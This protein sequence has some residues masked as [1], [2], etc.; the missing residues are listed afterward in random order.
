MSPLSPFEIREWRPSPT[1]A[2]Q[3]HAISDLEAGNVLYFPHLGFPFENGEEAMVNS[4]LALRPS[5]IRYRHGSDKLQGLNAQLLVRDHVAQILLR[6]SDHSFALVCALF[7]SYHLQIHPDTTRLDTTEAAERH[8]SRGRDSTRLHVDALPSTPLGDRRILRVCCNV[9]PNEQP[10]IWR[11]GQPFE[12][13]AARYAPL[14]Q[15]PLPGTHRLLHLLGATETKRSLYDHYVL[16][17]RKLGELDDEWQRRSPQ[18]RFAFAP[19]S[20]WMCLSDAV[21]HATVS[22]RFLLEQTFHLPLSAMRHPERSPQR[23]LERIT[24]LTMV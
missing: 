9:N 3:R 11:I 6:F 12:S 18:E 16:V 17:L 15:P 7:P 23:V 24:G 19:G 8:H 5:D 1:A 22:G 4:A 20:T 21:L 10:R 2:L 14:I 13:Y